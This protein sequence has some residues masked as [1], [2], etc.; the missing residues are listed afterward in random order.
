[1]TT[2]A[3]ASLATG[4]LGFAAG[5]F[6]ALAFGA[7]GSV[8]DQA[9]LF[10]LFQRGAPDI[11]GPRLDDLS[12]QGAAEGS[13]MRWALG[14]EVRSAGSI[15]W[16]TDLI[17]TRTTTS[18]GGK[19]GGGGSQT[20]FSYSISFAVHVCDTE[21]LPQNKIDKVLRIW[22]NGKIIYDDS[23]SEL[24]GRLEDIRFYEGDNSSADLLF[25]FENFTIMPAFKDSAYFAVED[26][27]LEDWG[28][29]LPNI[30]M[31]Y[32]ATDTQTIADAI[33]RICERGNLDPSEIDTSQVT[34]DM[35][36]MISVGEQEMGKLLEYL[37]LAY[38]KTAI[39]KNGKIVFFDREQ[40]N[41][42][43]ISDQFLGAHEEGESGDSIQYPIARSLTYDAKLPRKVSVRYIDPECDYEQSTRGAIKTNEAGG[44]L[45]RVELPMTLSPDEASQIA[46]RSLWTDWGVREEVSGSLP[47]SFVDIN[48]GELVRISDEGRD[49]LI[50]ITEISRGDN[51]LVKFKGMI[52]EPGVYD[53]FAYSEDRSCLASQESLLGQDSVFL[54]ITDHMI[55]D[56]ISLQSN[57]NMIVSGFFFAASET[58]VTNNTPFLTSFRIYT[59]DE[60]TGSFTPITIDPGNPGNG[61]QGSITSTFRKQMGFLLSGIPAPGNENGGIYWDR[62]TTFDFEVYD[63]DFV[64]TSLPEN[65]VLAGANS[66]VLME[67]SGSPELISFANV[68]SIGPR[69]Y[70]ASKILRGRRSTDIYAKQW[71]ANTLFT[72][73][74]LDFFTWSQSKYRPSLGPIT[75]WWKA[76]PRGTNLQDVS[77][78]EYGT[79]FGVVKPFPPAS[80]RKY[81]Q[82]NGDTVFG[83]HR[84]TRADHK[85]FATDIGF[86]KLS[87][88]IIGGGEI[89]AFVVEIYDPTD[90]DI[91]RTI[92]ITAPGFSTY[93]RA[94]E[95]E[96]GGGLVNQN[97][98]FNSAIYSF[99][100]TSSDRSDDGYGPTDPVNMR[101]YQRTNISWMGVG[102]PLVASI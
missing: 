74:N 7:L 86:R 88:P 17:E 61:G 29:R 24:D 48:P 57:P 58:E 102:H 101:I 26:L 43:D 9:F 40:L 34:G 44:E 8:I 70:R 63:P 98:L 67:E 69:Q 30:E 94:D 97:V 14:P 46:H 84:R 95:I 83:F 82:D 72:K 100:Y 71:G 2:V 42:K 87:H 22:A 6:G 50:R 53:Q 27:Q 79:E 15:V 16:S 76:A 77:S 35:R 10:P 51:Y 5:S 39:E 36:G 12:V 62:E 91:V 55:V 56:A 33:Q 59:D 25:D 80:L 3:F 60:E 73:P 38:N 31:L 49:E 90:T 85:M 54:A 65:E 99:V 89:Q 41:D 32:S 20:N 68:E 21:N 64:P 1:M 78:I 37:M 92:E 96:D 81:P 11:E 66:I 75:A 52:E 47:P 23:N 4:P 93:Y 18:T 19:G 13:P 28:N 45:K